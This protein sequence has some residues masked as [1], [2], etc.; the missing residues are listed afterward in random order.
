MRHKAKAKKLGRSAAHR[1]ATES[2]L[3]RGLIREDRI[4]TTLAKAKMARGLAEKMVTM[5]RKGTLAA[6]RNVVAALAKGEHVRRL[7]DVIV[8][9]CEGRQG[10]R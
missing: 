5:A 7:F 2:A 10:G 6:R 4:K 8:P 1:K 9:Q 3:V